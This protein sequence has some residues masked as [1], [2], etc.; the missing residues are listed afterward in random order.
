MFALFIHVRLILSVLEDSRRRCKQQGDSGTC[1]PAV[2]CR[3][4]NQNR[5]RRRSSTQA[6]GNQNYRT[7]HVR[8][9]HLVLH[10]I[11]GQEEWMSAYR[12]QA[13]AGDMEWD[14]SRID[15][16]SPPRGG[17]CGLQ[18]FEQ[19]GKQYS[20][21]TTIYGKQYTFCGGFQR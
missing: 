18:A 10:N 12:R 15:G 3:L 5:H 13:V 6:M 14:G 17:P 1:S 19:L 2:E 11:R 9:N 20:T 8:S 4:R 16:V 7:K 21:P